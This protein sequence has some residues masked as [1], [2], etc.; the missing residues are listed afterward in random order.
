VVLKPDISGTWTDLWLI[1][2]DSGSNVEVG[3]CRCTDQEG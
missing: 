3:S 1:P 2:E